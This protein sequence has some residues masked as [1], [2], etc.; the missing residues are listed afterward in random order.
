MIVEKWAGVSMRCISVLHSSYQKLKI[1]APRVEVM[2]FWH[3]WCSFRITA[4][5][6]R[7]PQTSEHNR[8]FPN[9]PGDPYMWAQL[10]I[11]VWLSQT[12]AWKINNLAWKRGKEFPWLGLMSFHSGFR[13]LNKSPQSEEKKKS[14]N[15]MADVCGFNMCGYNCDCE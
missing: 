8:S 3:V 13:W 2:H 12:L 4:L 1:T 7:M 11:C 14:A 15:R 6:S 5:P 10:I 9:I